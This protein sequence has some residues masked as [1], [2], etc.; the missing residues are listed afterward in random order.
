MRVDCNHQFVFDCMHA[1][2]DICEDAV[3]WD[4]AILTRSTITCDL[5]DVADQSKNGQ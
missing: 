2:I 5:F 1:F 3:S 4:A